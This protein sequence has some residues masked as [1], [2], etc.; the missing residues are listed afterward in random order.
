MPPLTWLGDAAG[1]NEPKYYETI[2]VTS[3]GAKLYVFGHGSKLNVSHKH[4]W[5]DFLK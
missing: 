3:I 1:W 5:G 4:L 2:H